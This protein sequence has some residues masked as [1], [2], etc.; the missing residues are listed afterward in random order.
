MADKYKEYG[1]LAVGLLLVL[2]GYLKGDLTIDAAFSNLL[3]IGGGAAAFA[4]VGV[5][6]VKRVKRKGR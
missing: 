1:V 6:R 2:I 4:Y 5:N 3:F